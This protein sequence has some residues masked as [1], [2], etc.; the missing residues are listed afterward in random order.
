M[1]RSIAVLALVLAGCAQPKEL[2]TTKI[3]FQL[4][5]NVIEITQPKDTTFGRLY[6]DPQKGVLE[7]EDYKSSANV[8][9]MATAEAQTQA[10]A[11]MF[12]Q[13]MEFLRTTRE[14]M[15]RAYGIPTNP[16]EKA[17]T[18]EYPPSGMKWRISTNGIPELAPKDDRPGG[19]LWYDDRPV[20][21]PWNEWRG[22]PGLNIQLTNFLW[23]GA[24][25]TNLISTNG[26]TGVRSGK[27]ITQ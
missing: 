21:Y 26:I 25:I 13:S 2:T 24:V 19:T 6:A 16:N 14:Q 17:I 5:T 7:V 9:A 1:N 10:Q 15:A 8:H 12:A 4:G 18:Y 23:N 22:Y 3:R 27:I 11:Q 20:P